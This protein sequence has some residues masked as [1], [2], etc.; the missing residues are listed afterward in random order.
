[1]G[2]VSLCATRA[3]PRSGR[4]N[5]RRA[6]SSRRP[7]N[8]VHRGGTWSGSFIADAKDVR[9]ASIAAPTSPTSEHLKLTHEGAPNASL[10]QARCSA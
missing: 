8:S 6:R 7:L 4:I 2:R 1:M 5:A 9:P 3:H 10:R